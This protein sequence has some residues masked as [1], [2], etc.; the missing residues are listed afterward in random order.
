[1]A[2]GFKSG[3]APQMEQFVEYKQTTRK[4]NSS[5]IFH[6]GCFDK[7]CAEKFPN[8]K[9]LCIEM[10]EWCLEKPTEHGNTCSYRISPIREFVN[11]SRK[12]KWTTLEPPQP[13]AYKPRNYVP[14]FFT[15]D[16]K[17][18][19]FIECDKFAVNYRSWQSDERKILCPMVIPTI[20]RLLYSTG[21]RTNEV[22]LLKCED[23]DFMTG[24]I[25]INDSK[26]NDRHR[27]AMHRSLWDL[28]IRYHEA[29]SRHLHNRIYFFPDEGDKPYSPAWM[30]TTFQRIWKNVN[31]SQKA[32][33]YN[34]RHNYAIENI[35]RWKNVG[36][37]IND[38]LIYLGRTMGHVKFSST[39]YYFHLAPCFAS[40]L[41]DLCDDKFNHLLPDFDHGK[42]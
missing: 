34:L 20:Y 22:R 6:L 36:Y 24:V 35:N 9:E 30:T 17:V 7:Y 21:M 42:E 40:K 2:V 23:I 1:M 38:K 37:E 31:S 25:N 8:A 11:F 29:M 33:P 12:M 32:N 14:H 4:W 28:L 18:R 15:E 26:G 13:P 16:E 5:S 10:F 41:K 39:L 19:F 27:V 3:L